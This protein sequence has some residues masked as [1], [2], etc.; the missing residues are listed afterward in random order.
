MNVIPN[1]RPHSANSY[2]PRPA[3]GTRAGSS[4]GEDRVTLSAA[5]EKRDLRKMGI[6]GGVGTAL[7]VAAAALLCPAAGLGALV[8]AGLVGGVTGAAI[9]DGALETAGTGP[10][11]KFDPLNIHDVLDPDNLY[12]PRNPFNPANPLYA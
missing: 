1:Y 11:R 2:R 10:A 12:H 3:V 6:L 9:G 8:M 7:G 4:R 5:A